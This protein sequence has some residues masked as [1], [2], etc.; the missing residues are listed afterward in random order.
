M[1]DPVGKGVSAG[2]CDIQ[3]DAF[4]GA[5]EFAAGA[6]HVDAEFVNVLADF[7]ADLDDRLMHFAF[8]LFAK[9]RG[10]GGDELAD[11]RTELTCGWIY[12]LKFFLDADREAVTHERNPLVHI[13]RG[14]K[15][16]SQFAAVGIRGLSGGGGHGWKARTFGDVDGEIRGIGHMCAASELCGI[17]CARGG[18]AW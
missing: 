10:G 5:N 15:M 8:D 17:I 2:G 9:I 12:D 14:C 6:V 18:A 13:L 4:G 3:A 1:V 7:G 16:L 11:V